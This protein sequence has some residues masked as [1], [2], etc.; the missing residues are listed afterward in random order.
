MVSIDVPGYGALRI[1][2]LVMDFNGTLAID[3]G[4]IRGVK[5]RLRRLAKQLDLHVV[6]A[7]TFGRAGSELE[8]LPCKI[9]ILERRRQDRAKAAYVQRLGARAT[10]CIGNGRN[11][12][13]M[14]DIAALGIA[15]M[16]DEGVAMD[17]VRNADLV[18]RDI[19]DALDLLLHPM[20][21]VASLRN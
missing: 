19:P 10:A 20:R 9:V 14:L 2:H 1:A 8:G 13:A 11:D 7:D 17:A 12:R 16:Q 5:G 18:V 21:L 15:V 6:T 3:G 4:L